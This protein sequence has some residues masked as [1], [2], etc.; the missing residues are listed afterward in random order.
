MNN[1]TGRACLSLLTL[2]K[3]WDKN[4]RVKV[5]AKTV[6]VGRPDK[7]SWNYGKLGDQLMTD[8]DALAEMAGRNCYQSWDRPN[9]KT[10]PNRG[11]LA[12][13]LNQGHH[14]V[15]EHSSVSFEVT[16]VSTMLLGQLTR[17]RHLSFS[18]E[19]A[20]FVDRGASD[21]VFSNE[22]TSRKGLAESFDYVALQAIHAYDSAIAV[23][24]RS[25]LS[26][27]EA[28]QAARGILP[29]GI[30]TK[31]VVTGNLRAWREVI[32]KRSSPGADVEI[33]EL[34]NLILAELK[35]LAPNTFQDM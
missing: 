27:K 5:L 35:V 17:H 3:R 22:I 26:R 7:W 8:M 29:Q 30:E 14:S 28:R 1:P 19:S 16:G 24:M 31:I 9:D 34:A 20:R 32:S 21:M 6:V 12:N 2:S 33:R 4:M 13:I 18:V 23:L 10:A 11:Y 15:L 25:G